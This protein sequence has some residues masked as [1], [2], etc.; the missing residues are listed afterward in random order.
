MS[1][2]LIIGNGPAAHRLVE[3]LR[4]H[5]HDG[6]I[7]VLGAED[8]PAYNRVLLASVL[9]GTLSAA[10]VTLPG[11]RAEVRL[12]VT[13]TAVDR[14]RRLVHTDAGV[15]H[16]YDELVLATGARAT[17]PD[18]PGV[19]GAD[20]ALAAGVTPLRTL[21]DCARLAGGA[22]D[23]VVLGGG[24][25]GVETA[26]GL[27][28][29]G[30]DVA[31]VHPREHPMDHRLDAAGGAL[32]GDHLRG[33]GLR[34]RFGRRAARYRPGELV[35]DDGE[36]L[37]AD[38]LVLCT[39][40]TPETGLAAGAGLAVGRGVLVDDHLT[41]SDPHV[42]A[43]GDCAEHDGR[44]PGLIAPAW[45]QAEVL[46]RRLTG[47]T[48]RYRGIGA[49]TRLKARGI[50][51]ASIGA[52]DLLDGTDPGVEL[53]T[54]SDPGQG[55]YAKLAVRAE[56]VAG[57]VLIGFPQATAT[58]AQLHDR[59]LPLPADR[60][61]M[62]LGGSPAADSGDT[63][64]CRCN[65]VTKTTLVRAWHRGA[66]DVGGLARTTRATTG[67]GGCADEVRGLCAAL[68]TGDDITTEQEGAA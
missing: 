68:S 54:L 43:L 64:V 18:V 51:L 23:V 57:A 8:R 16:R 56:R 24:V 37:A 17:V 3:R 1:H 52:S 15:V 4:Q 67:C 34:T 13:A 12:G 22:R 27:H 11:S 29:R 26:R 49:V 38:A 60:L 6:P 59:D 66:R 33:A 53:V 10:S 41:T 2:V 14:A 45:E 25:L 50:E 21:D 46:A 19:R 62:L 36:A 7:T 48:A 44:V 30:L 63:V 61:G 31:L 55:R 35:L 32:L 58:V 40:V 42:H 20:G 5:G 39:G 65:N 9:D 47:G 28:G